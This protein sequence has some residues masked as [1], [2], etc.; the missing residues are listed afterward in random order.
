MTKN[1][2]IIVIGLGPAGMAVSAMGSA[3]GLNVAV[4]EKN[5]LG[6]ECLNVGCMPSKGIL[7]HAKKAFLT[8]EKITPFEQ[9]QKD[10]DYIVD[11]K[12][13]D[14][15][16]DVTI[17]YEKAEFINKNTIKAGAQ[18]LTGKKIFIA[19]GTEPFIPPIEGIND[20]DYLTNN[21]V[22]ALKKVPKSM[23]IIGGGAIGSEMAQAF[24]RLGCK[25]T[26]VQ[27]DKHLIPNGEEKAGRLLEE[28]LNEEGIS[29]FNE[30][31][32]LKTYQDDENITIE[33][34]K[35]EKITSEKLL[36]AA[37]RKFT[38]EGL[39]LSKAGIKTGKRGEILVD[40]YLRT[41][42][43]KIYAVGDCNGEILLSHAAMHQGM[44]ALM[45]S[46]SPIKQDFRK[47]PIPWTVF[48]EPQVSHVGMTEKQL[49][50][51][52]IKYDTIKTLYSD[53]GAAIVEDKTVGFVRVYVSKFGKIY[54]ASIVGDGSGE[55]INEWTLAIQKGM[56]LIDI[57]MTAH[58]FPTMGFLTK[59]I[60]EEWMM[61]KM[62]N[63][64]L[65]K[66]IVFWNKIFT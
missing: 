60:G 36:V 63:P 27:F 25:T 7:E 57:M 66:L 54:G 37:G 19:T 5:K 6:G 61:S 17:I 15:F 39:E 45:N 65:K 41:T 14:V 47:S 13:K 59:R 32:I 11:W 10:L 21:N 20:V 44:I 53:Y 3:M 18:I 46:M 52:K 62:E 30:R 26:I 49:Q 64:T 8:Q 35:G 38:P 23:T 28:K 55:M 31:K 58:S 56:N 29:I 51:K 16:K 33:T 4:I 48:T 12:V 40:K 2:D 22:F 42:N 43:K 1:F 34:D 50:N 9:I 24:S